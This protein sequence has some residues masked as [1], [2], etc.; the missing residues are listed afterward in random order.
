MFILTQIL[1]LLK[2]SSIISRSATNSMYCFIKSQFMPI[3]LTGRA[4]VRNSCGPQKVEWEGQCLRSTIHN[5]SKF[6]LVHLHVNTC[7][8]WTAFK[9][10][11][12]TVASEGLFTKCLNIRQAKSQWRPWKP[13]TFN[14]FAIQTTTSV[15][16][17]T[18][19]ITMHSRYLI[20]ADEFIG[21]GEA[22]HKAPLLQPENCSKRPREED[23]LHSSKSHHSLACRQQFTLNLNLKDLQVSSRIVF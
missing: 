5:T 18:I 20:S 7:S 6:N 10:M 1:T 8:I 11:L 4:W 14:Q 23:S 21:E 16:F 9:M 22:W 13:K 12:L 19:C 17:V 15:R 3:S 2:P